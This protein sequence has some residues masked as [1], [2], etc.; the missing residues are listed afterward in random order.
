ML[1]TNN[2]K[3]DFFSCLLLIFFSQWLLWV[4]LSSYVKEPHLIYI[5]FITI[6][7]VFIHEILG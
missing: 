7:L 2:S 3:Q 6:L 1:V 4:V 5:K